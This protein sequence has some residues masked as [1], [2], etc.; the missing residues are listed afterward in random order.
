ML[1]QAQHV[2][3]TILRFRHL[4][5]NNDLAVNMLRVFSDLLHRKGLM[6]HT[7]TAVD[8]A[9]ISALSSN[10]NLEVGVHQP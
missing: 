1:T 7:G 9:L 3:T 6:L 10:K 8:A 4:L 5:E 2:W